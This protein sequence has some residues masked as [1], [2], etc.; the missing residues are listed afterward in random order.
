MILIAYK[1]LEG[2]RIADLKIRVWS[3][4]L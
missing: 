1:N 4:Q 2:G 3:E